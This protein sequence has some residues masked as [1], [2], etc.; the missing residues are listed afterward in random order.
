MD[1]RPRPAPAHTILCVDGEKAA[2]VFLSKPIR[3]DT[4][5]NNQ[6]GNKKLENFSLI[7]AEYGFL[8]KMT[9]AAVAVIIVGILLRKRPEPSRN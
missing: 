4:P 8:L 2:L 6:A 7:A 1:A 5:V 9:A 3:L